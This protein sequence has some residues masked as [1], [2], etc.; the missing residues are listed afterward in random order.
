M[1]STPDMLASGKHA[2]K[3]MLYT[4]PPLRRL[5]RRRGKGG[6]LPEM[7]DGGRMVRMRMMVVSM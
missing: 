2:F 6:I 5:L 7:A 4:S 1:V 3:E